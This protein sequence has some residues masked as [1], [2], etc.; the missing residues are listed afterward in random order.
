MNRPTA[1]TATARRIAPGEM[2]IWPMVTPCEIWV[3]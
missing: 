3:S 2:V 1:S